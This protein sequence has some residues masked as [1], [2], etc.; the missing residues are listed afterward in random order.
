LKH[1]DVSFI[2]KTEVTVGTDKPP[3]EFYPMISADT[4]SGEVKIIPS[5][6]WWSATLLVTDGSYLPRL[7][8]NGKIHINLDNVTYIK[9]V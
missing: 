7:V 2:D 5:G 4:E 9:E 1:Y 3:T 8:A 6:R